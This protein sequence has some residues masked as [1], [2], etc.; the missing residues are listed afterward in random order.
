MTQNLFTLDE[1]VIT[2]TKSFL[3]DQFMITDLDG[4]PVGTI[5]QSTSLK[6][7]VLKSSRSLEVAITDAE[8]NPLQ[9]VMTISDPPNFLRDTYEVHLPGIEQP[10][11]VITK[12]FSMLKTK[13]ELTMKG[14]PDVEIHGDFWDWNL[15]IT[16]RGR[17][18]ANVTNE[19]TGVGN[20]FMG[21]N[22]YRLAI[23]P[24]L[25]EQQHAAILGAVMSMDML[26]TK[27]KNSD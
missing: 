1:L 15:S 4:T 6:D 16:S 25:K 7:M 14:F 2:Q 26:R 17:R 5:L 3:N 12:R 23:T 21:K 22:T 11:A 20:Y 9:T 10:M 13:L 8:G 27:Q 19:W 24:G 18:L